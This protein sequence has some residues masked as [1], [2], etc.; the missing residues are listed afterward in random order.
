VY[1]SFL[2]LRREA[3]ILFSSRSACPV[4]RR[5]EE[6]Q[7][8]RCFLPSIF[9]PLAFAVVLSASASAQTPDKPAPD[10]K[11]ARPPVCIYNSGAY[12]D[13]AFVCV[14]KSLMLKCAVDDA[15][16]TW[17]VVT[18]KDL[19]EKC[20]APAARGTVYQQRARSNR[21]NIRRQITPPG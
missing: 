2:D 6:I 11:S 9:T 7:M 18:D 21:Q 12:S 20:L 15:R 19:G 14:Q 1:F 16:A 3:L 8:I 13:G 17:A 10:Q 4:S 5:A